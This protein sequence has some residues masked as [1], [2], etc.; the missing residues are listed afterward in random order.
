VKEAVVVAYFK[1]IFRHSS[2]GNGNISLP[3]WSRNRIQSKLS[4]DYES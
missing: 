4:L 2:G 3:N 1:M